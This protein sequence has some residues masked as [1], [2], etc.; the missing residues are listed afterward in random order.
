MLYCK[1]MVYVAK[2]SHMAAERRTRPDRVRVARRR[3]APKKQTSL[4][5]KF[6]IL[7]LVI[8]GAFLL[9]R[10]YVLWEIRG[11]MK[12]TVRQEEELSEEN[13]RLLNERRSSSIRMSSG[14]GLVNSSDWSN[15]EKF[16]I[17]SKTAFLFTFL[18]RIYSVYSKIIIEFFTCDRYNGC[19]RSVP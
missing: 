10:F 16:R 11:D 12:N 17:S 15:R 8:G 4:Y 6:I 19:K 2:E 5:K 1:R 14:S 3:R 13:G 9:N 7:I 18:V